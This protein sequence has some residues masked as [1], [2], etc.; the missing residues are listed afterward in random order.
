MSNELT[1]TT[2]TFFYSDLISITKIQNWNRA[3]KKDYR[4]TEEIYLHGICDLRVRIRILSWYRLSCQWKGKIY[5]C[6][7]IHLQSR[8]FNMS[9]YTDG[10]KKISE[11]VFP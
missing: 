1:N 4:Y 9:C 6:D 10:G 2:K 5:T 7:C 11:Y 3:I 8:E